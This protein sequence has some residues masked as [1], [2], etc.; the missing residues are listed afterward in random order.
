MKHTTLLVILI[1]IISFA[2]S[3]YAQSNGLI[4]KNS[5]YAWYRD[6]I[7]QGEYLGE[8]LSP[9]H[10]SSNFEKERSGDFRGEWTPKHDFSHCPQLETSFLLENTLYNMSLDEMIN[11]IEPD[12]TLRT[13]S[14]FPGVWTRDV[15]YSIILS[16]AYM[17]PKVS[18][19]CLLRKVDR[20][21]R[22]IQDTGTGGSWPCSTDRMVWAVAAW[23]IYKVTGSREWLAHVYPII[24][25]SVE[26][27][28]LTAYDENTG[29]VR[30]ESSFIDWRDQSYPRWMQP[31]DIFES[32]C[33]GTNVVHAEAL[34]V[35]SCMAGM[36]N[37]TSAQ[38]KYEKK[39]KQIAEAIN[40]YLW[41][42]EKGYYAQFLYGRN[43]NTLSPRSESLGESLAI[44]WGVA[45]EK[46]RAEVISNS[47]V[48]E[49]G[50]P[51]F[52]PEI[53]N[54]PP[55]HNNAVWPF[56]SS[57][58][59]QAA[60]MVENETAVMHAIGSIYRAAALFVT[61]KE[62]FVL[63][64]GNFRGTQINSSNMLWSLSG[65]LS[66]VY[67]ILMG[68]HFDT[69][70]LLFKP[71]IPKV[72]GGKRVLKGFPYRNSILNIEVE[73]YGSKIKAFY[74]DGK[75]Q[76][77]IVEGTLTGHHKVKI[78][79]ADN[80]IKEQKINLQPAIASVET[81]V[82][83][84]EDGNQMVW[85]K[86][87]GAVAYQIL[88]NGVNYKMVETA[89][90]GLPGD[91]Y[92]EYQVVALS[93]NKYASSFASEPV[94]VGDYK[95]YEV[96][97]FAPK[98]DRKHKGYM[99]TGFV[100]IDKKDNT[101]I[102][103]PVT[104]EKEGTYVIDFRYAN[105]NNTIADDNRCAIRTLRADDH[106][107]GVSVFPQRGM[108]AWENWGWSNGHRIHLSAGEHIISLSFESHNENMNIDVNQAL[109]DQLRLMR[110]G[111][112]KK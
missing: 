86:I 36:M 55:Y 75:K 84:L 112:N 44:L 110:V 27:D 3:C 48:C 90:F 78:I 12:S 26:D 91:A 17:Q 107:L 16:M 63:S 64:T 67:R 1:A 30:G 66:I 23:E 47:P 88:R 92:G 28:Y 69:E 77:P 8:A 72:L 22:I 93:E 51:I 53:P 58:W 40:R 99:G 85:D 24:R 52:Y 45:P 81:P 10:L 19:N 80:A 34:R 109:V 71:F 33:L 96:E 98:S 46:R 38:K 82:V 100:N 14:G 9:T 4:F 73:G 105:G 20:F 42:P 59:M 57:Y 18:M 37:D 102:K 25:K 43:Y 95:T 76:K 74:L 31:V 70:Q 32:K 11:A 97:D 41:M 62:N 65:N 101:I 15:S 104:I 50:T 83:K 56:V 94:T 21:G 13:G 60:A 39:S 106:L 5:Q 7:E 111:M 54:I 49:F 6:R 79:M 89:Q 35:L 87:E 68:I 61:N 2:D 29:L 103:I 108:H